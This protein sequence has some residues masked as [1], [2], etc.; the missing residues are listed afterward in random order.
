[1]KESGKT[2]YE[3]KKELLFSNFFGFRII[4]TET[5]LTLYRTTT[6]LEWSKLKASADEKKNDSKIKFC[7]GKSRK[8]HCGKRRKCCLPAV[9]PIPTNVFKSLHFQ[10]H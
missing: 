9:S 2:L 7:F 4:T 10:G 6:F 1:M 5:G 3:K 8:K